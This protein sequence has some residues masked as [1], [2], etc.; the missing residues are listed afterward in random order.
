MQSIDSKI[1][2]R[3]YGRRK[4]CVV[5]PGDF[6]DLGSRQAVDLA[7]HRMAKKGML[8]RLTRGLYDYPRIDSDLGP[9]H[10]SGTGGQGSGERDLVPGQPL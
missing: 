9:L 2:I 10:P 8:R 1:L 7:L 4:G 6:L 3:I 5:I